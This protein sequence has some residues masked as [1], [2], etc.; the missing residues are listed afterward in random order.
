MTN[1]RRKFH[2]DI[3]CVPFGFANGAAS[4]QPFTS[5]EKKL[6]IEEKI[7]EEIKGYIDEF[8][9]VNDRS[10]RIK[11]KDFSLLKFMRELNYW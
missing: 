7:T 3:E 2:T 1:N 6:M 10:V 4:S 9:S 11:I 8:C 5:E